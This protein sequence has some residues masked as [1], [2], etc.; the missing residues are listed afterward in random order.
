MPTTC[1]Q[2]ISLPNY[3]I[4]QFLLIFYG[5]SFAARVSMSFPELSLSHSSPHFW[6][7]STKK[8]GQVSLRL[9]Q[10]N[11]RG[12][13]T[14]LFFDHS[15]L[16]LQSTNLEARMEPLQMEVQL[17]IWYPPGLFLHCEFVGYSSNWIA[18]GSY[19]PV[20]TNFLPFSIFQNLW[21]Y[22]PYSCRVES[23]RISCSASLRILNYIF[24]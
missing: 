2:G 3:F 18:V 6:E 7:H 24:F 5:K 21:F 23:Y 14:S 19:F 4:S 1:S 13:L 8:Q 20:H 22:Y 12:W 9:W 17:A 10:S 15:S 11:N 16:R